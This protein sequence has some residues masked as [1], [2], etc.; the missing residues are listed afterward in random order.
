MDST[1]TLHSLIALVYDAAL[2]PAR[3]PAFL[4]AFARAVSAAGAALLHNDLVSPCGTIMASHEV[5]PESQRLYNEHF[6]EIDPWLLTGRRRGTLQPGIVHIGEELVPHHELVR[7]QY[8]SDLAR[9]F[10]LTRCLPAVI[11]QDATT[12]ASISA[13]RPDAMDEF[14]EPQRALLRDLMPHLQRALQ[15]HRRVNGLDL[16]TQALASALD[17]LTT[18]AMIVRQDMTLVLANR[19]AERILSARDGLA[20]TPRGIAAAS[21]GDHRRLVTLVIAAAQTSAGRGIS[22]GGAMPVMRP[23]GRRAFHV[24]VTPLRVGVAAVRGDHLR[25]VAGLFVG[26]PDAAP[27]PG[28]PHMSQLYGLTPTE[29]AI[30]ASIANGQSL[31]E[32]AQARGITVQTARWHLKQVLSKTDT[33][34]Q[35][36]LVRLW[37]TAGVIEQA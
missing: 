10:G 12:I 34:S 13:L 35:A 16:M 24:L 21:P 28:G 7:T 18:G 3:W 14:Q 11:R 23:S 2:N 25:A 1:A 4:E 30:A 26:D 8:Y 22:S 32:V 29:A 19:A 31:R 17:R 20:S 5:D 37:L 33:H 6:G 27:E 15:I 36:A 9:P